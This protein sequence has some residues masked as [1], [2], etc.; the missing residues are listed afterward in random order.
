M[1]SL[2]SVIIPVYNREKL[3]KSCIDSV[4]QQSYENLEIIIVN[5]GS[6]DGTEIEIMKYNDNR[7]KYYY[8]KNSGKPAAARNLGLRN[9]RGEYIAFLDSDDIW[10][11][12]KIER[13]LSFFTNNIL[14]LTSEIFYFNNAIS[15]KQKRM[16]L[17][18]PVIYCITIDKLIKNNLIAT[19]SVIMR[20]SLLSLIGYFNETIEGIGEDWDY[21]LRVL[22]YKRD[23]VYLLSEKLTGYRIHSSNYS[24][25]GNIPQYNSERVH[26]IRNI[27]SDLHI[28][29]SESANIRI[30][31]E[32]IL[33][34][35]YNKDKK[36][37]I[38]ILSGLWFKK[39]FSCKERFK[40]TLVLF[41]IKK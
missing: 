34:R 27:L 5:D 2:V 31:R 15:N 4:I 40:N 7:I 29:T 22:Q 12:N 6:D 39:G 14:L 41:G 18:I 9:A 23:S 13:Q 38:S 11:P 8:Q 21:W 24:L 36:D 19:S 28:L 26:N 3:I 10:N 25:I 37:K 32:I 1:N 33:S 35:L 16:S 30:N 20:K 17:D